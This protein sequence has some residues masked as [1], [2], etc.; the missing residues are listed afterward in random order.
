MDDSVDSKL[1]FS[2][3]LREAWSP[4]TR[5]HLLSVVDPPAANAFDPNGLAV[6]DEYEHYDKAMTETRERLREAALMLGEERCSFS[7][8]QGTPKEVILQRARDSHAQLILIGAT[9]TTGLKARLFGC[10]ST[11]IATHA[12]CSVHVV[13]NNVVEL[14]KPNPLSS[15]VRLAG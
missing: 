14:E 7:I 10:L 2:Y 5:F 6:L 11:D 15:Y 9:S 13:R 4:D 8:E 3:A 1:A 12:E